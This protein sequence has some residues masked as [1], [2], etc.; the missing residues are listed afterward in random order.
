[1]Q[2]ANVMIKSYP[3]GVSIFL[4]EACSFEQILQEIKV[5][6]Q[7]SASFFKD[8][9]LVLSI[10]GRIVDKQEE[11]DIIRVISE[12]SNVHICCL[13][14]KDEKKN[15][16]F[17]RAIQKVNEKNQSD[18]T[19]SLAK[20]EDLVIKGSVK[21]LQSIESDATIIILG[22]VLMGASVVSEKNIII[23]GGLYGEAYA[24]VGNEDEHFVVALDMEPT[25][26]KIGS[27]TY[28]DAIKQT[29]W[30]LK[31]KVA[32]Q[33]AYVN[34]KTVCLVPIQKGFMDTIS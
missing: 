34:E 21:D 30:P 26:L 23:L 8:A 29:K 27:Y 14:G 4:N 1:M 3:N 25:S 19:D 13:I 12:N 6:F 22:D 11:L 28:N 33:F 32:A 31:S 18:T 2:E 10:E 17:I 24:G 15:R 20:K 9:N 7:K 16:A 5:T